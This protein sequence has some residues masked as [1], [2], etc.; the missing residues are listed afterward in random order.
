MKDTLE[1][2]IT[3]KN[4]VNGGDDNDTSVG[5]DDDDGGKGGNIGGQHFLP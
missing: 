4:P 2:N 5:D 1:Y 3:F